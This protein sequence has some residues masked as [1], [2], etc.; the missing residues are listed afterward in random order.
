MYKY[1]CACTLHIYN[2]NRTESAAGVDGGISGMSLFYMHTN[3]F[4]FNIYSKGHKSVQYLYNCLIILFNNIDILCYLTRIT[5]NLI[6]MNL[7][8]FDLPDMIN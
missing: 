4:L 3:Y 7:H 1:M 8:E 6:L 2:V 5:Q